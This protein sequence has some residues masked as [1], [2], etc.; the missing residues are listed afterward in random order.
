MAS[1][2]TTLLLSLILFKDI[3]ISKRLSIQYV[4]ELI[5]LFCVSLVSQSGCKTTTFILTGKYFLKFF[6]ENFFSF[7]LHLSVFQVVSFLSEAV[8]LRG[9]KVEMFFV[10]PNFFEVFFK[11]NFCLFF[12]EHSLVCGVQK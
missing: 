9:A 10:I 2:L 5:I 4:Y 1:N 8:V 7:F 3:A 11:L 6:L 12:Y